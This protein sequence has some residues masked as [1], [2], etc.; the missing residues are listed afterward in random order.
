MPKRK[1]GE[2]EERVDDEGEL[3]DEEMPIPLDLD[4]KEVDETA[5]IAKNKNARVE[6]VVKVK[7]SDGDT[8]HCNYCEFMA[9]SSGSGRIVAEDGEVFCHQ[10]EIEKLKD[11]G[12]LLRFIEG[13]DT[14]QAPTSNNVLDG[15]QMNW[16]KNELLTFAPYLSPENSEAPI[17]E[18]L[19]G[20]VA[21]YSVDFEFRRGTDKSD[22][23]MLNLIE[24]R[25]Y[26]RRRQRLYG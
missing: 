14:S 4:E 2:F 5:A 20:L 7:Y 6:H 13:F 10:E 9:I 1:G 17:P 12:V 25:G 22:E 21:R 15:T 26:V 8:E 24:G 19:I 18:E 23:A 11:S 3:G 16:K